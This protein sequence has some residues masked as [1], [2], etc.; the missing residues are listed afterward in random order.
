MCYGSVFIYLTVQEHC[1]GSDTIRFTQYID[2]NLGRLEVCSSG[3]WG[4]VCG[5]DVTDNIAIVACRELNHAAMGRYHIIII[6]YIT[7]CS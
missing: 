6:S 2:D 1:N 4:S 5:N 7:L 3:I